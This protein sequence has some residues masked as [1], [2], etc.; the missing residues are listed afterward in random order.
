MTDHIPCCADASRSLHMHVTSS[1]HHQENEVSSKE[2]D[3]LYNDDKGVEQE[4]LN[5]GQRKYVLF[6][7][8]G[9]FPS[10]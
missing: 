4:T 3:F 7:T 1:Q 2:I 5:V 10:E 9:D 6:S 8:E